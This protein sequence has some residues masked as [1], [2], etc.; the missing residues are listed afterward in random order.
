[1]YERINTTTPAPTSN[2]PVRPDCPFWMC[3]RRWFSDARD[4]CLRKMENFTKINPNPIMAIAVRT[5][6]RKVRS[7][8]RW[9]PVL[10]ETFLSIIFIDWSNDDKNCSYS[11]CFHGWKQQ[12]GAIFSD[13]LT[14]IGLNSFSCLI[15]VIYCFNLV[16]ADV[17]C[18]S[19][20]VS[21][22]KSEY[23]YG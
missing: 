11:D 4:I 7:L 13:F 21:L 14:L 5:Q 19:N 15:F 16:I 23:G 22:I 9:S 10:L 12:S 8:A 1:M 20:F 3:E 6:A 18:Y 2:T 17:H